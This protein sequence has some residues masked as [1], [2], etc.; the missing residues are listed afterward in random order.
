MADLPDAR[1]VF[2][3][4]AGATK[5]F[6][7]EAPFA[8]DDYNLK[9]LLIHFRSFHY[10]NKLLELEHDRRS[11]GRINIEQLMTRLQGR[12]PYDTGEAV[13]QQAPLLSELKREFVRR[14][15]IAR[16]GKFHKENLAALAQTCVKRGV[17]CITFN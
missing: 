6:L 11:D 17:T 13:Q 7:E 2:V 4:G 9:D 5:A 10:A 16:K 12:M 14:I 15:H 8:I 1:S 3:L